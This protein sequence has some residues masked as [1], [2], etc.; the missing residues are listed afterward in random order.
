MR[1]SALSAWLVALACGAC[2]LGSGSALAAPQWLPATNLSGPGQDGEIPLVAVDP[3]GDATAVWE[4][5]NG[6]NTVIQAATR[7]AGGT[8]GAP[9]TL[10]A[11]GE[12]SFAPDVAVDAQGD[13]TAVW[14]RSTG[15][16]GDTVQQA[17]FRPAAGVWQAPVDVSAAGKTADRVAVA[18]DPQGDATALWDIF[19]GANYIMQA[20]SRP[21][22]GAWGLAVD[23][24]GSGGDAVWPQA[25]YDAHGDVTAVWYRSQ[26]ANLIVQAASRPAGGVWQ[27]AIDLSLPGTATEPQVA[28]DP[29]GDATAV[30][31]RS[32]GANPIVQAA[33]LPAGGVWQSAVDLSTAGQSADAPQVAVDAQGNATAVWDRSN[34]ANTI[35]QAA[36]RPAGGSWQAP[37]DLSVGG[38]DALLAQVAVDPQ[39][40]AVAVWYRRNGT[41]WIVQAAQRP[42][43]GSWQAPVD[44]ADSGSLAPLPQVAVDG[45]GNATAVWFEPE[46]STSVAEAAGLDAAGPLL[47]GLSVPVSGVVGV[48][49]SLSVSPL[50][51][52]SAVASTGWSFG[53]G[54]G[55][56]G[57]SVSHTYAAP[58][59]YTVGLSSSDVLG[60][61]TSSS[62]SIAIAP[63]PSPPSVAGGPLALTNVSQ[64]HRSWREGNRGA[65]I[66]RRRTGR[67]RRAPVGTRFAFTVN[68]RVRVTLSFT[69]RVRRRTF[70]RGTLSMSAGAGRR[71]IAFQGRIGR[72]RLP[73]GPYTLTITA[74]EAQR[75]LHFTIVK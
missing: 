21:A 35:V 28:V 74:A 7:P 19:T 69:Q 8:W 60:N 63:S 25:S 45:H 56:A 42:A 33:V 39:G 18:V 30:W 47:D 72:R 31:L 37:V 70:T 50:D 13:A 41:D 66:A 68:Q 64:T 59:T 2:L 52:F 6:T 58:G 73:L 46:G 24:T 9:V 62:A 16:G 36:Q 43:G 57:A 10:S 34:G 61:S 54:Q 14:E 29:R 49:V 48:P 5:N 17:A 1:C 51:V 67:A 71:Q 22:G 11:G 15:I 65:T 27:S 55:A 75:S 23:L 44:L 53:D 40:D 32:N 20:A 3:R 12:N 38:A 4:H 26:G